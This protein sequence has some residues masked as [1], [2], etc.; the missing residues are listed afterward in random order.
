MRFD[1]QDNDAI[2]QWY[3][4][5]KAKANKLLQF[6]VQATAFMTITS[7]VMAALWWIHAEVEYRR[8]LH[9][10][11]D[12][13]AHVYCLDIGD[14]MYAALGYYLLIV[15]AVPVVTL[16]ARSITRFAIQRFRRQERYNHI[17]WWVSAYCLLC[18]SGVVVQVVAWVKVLAK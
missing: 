10:V 13:T 16:V 14:N 6:G 4:W 11:Q 9:I 5:T 1:P 17:P 8:C 15:I 7:V 3:Q 12:A 18:L 2:W